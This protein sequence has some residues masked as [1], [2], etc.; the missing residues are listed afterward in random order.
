M[1]KKQADIDVLR[2]CLVDIRDA[3]ED[4]RS[5]DFESHFT[6]MIDVKTYR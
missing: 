4:D 3:S 5:F 6:D 1:V 2:D